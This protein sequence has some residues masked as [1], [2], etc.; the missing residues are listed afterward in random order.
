MEAFFDFAGA[1]PIVTVL[2]AVLLTSAPVRII[3]AFRRP[4]DLLKLL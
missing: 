2:L 4:K 1:H 3:H